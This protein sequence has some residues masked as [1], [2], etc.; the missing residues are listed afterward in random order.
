MVFFSRVNTVNKDT[1]KVFGASLLLR[2][3][4]SPAALDP[5]R[6]ARELFV[7]FV[8]RALR[9]KLSHDEHLL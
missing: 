8:N 7:L 2:E 3:H 9:L 6:N 5:L 1:R 4:S